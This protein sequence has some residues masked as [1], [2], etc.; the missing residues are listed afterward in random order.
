MS[1]VG[2]LPTI[3]Q[4]SWPQAMR[5]VSFGTMDEARQV[6]DFWF[7]KLPMSALALN[8]R[9]KF[10]FADDMPELL[11]QQ[12]DEAIRARFGNLVERAGKGEFAGW[13]D[14][15]RRCLSLIILLD[16]FP[17]DIHRDTAQAFAYDEQAL[18]LT[19]SGTQSAADG[20]LDVV[21]RIFFYMPLQHCEVREVQDE[22]VAGYRR[23]VTEAPQELRSVFEQCL[24]SAEE[25][26][27]IIER[28]GRFPHRNRVLQRVNTS[29]EEAWLRGSAR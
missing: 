24:A 8:Q 9:V 11:R 25:H 17:R 4:E 7:G 23:L 20:A 14:S 22:S 16:Q 5:I 18:A 15:P 10:W 13:A 29:D 2:G 6:R 21:E 1:R 19:L 12:R 3:P 26:R 28:F 27:A